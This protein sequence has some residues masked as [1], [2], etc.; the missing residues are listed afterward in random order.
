ME[1]I[2]E[3]LV[4]RGYAVWNMSYRRLGEPFGGWPAGLDDAIAGI[5]ALQK[6]QREGADL[7]LSRVVLVGHS[8][9]GHLA[10]MAAPRLNRAWRLSKVLAVAGLAPVTDLTAADGNHDDAE[11]V[12]GLLGSA[13]TRDEQVEA[14]PID[15]LPLG[16]A[17]LI[18][19]GDRD[20]A[21]PLAMSQS[22]VARASDAGDQITLSVVYGGEHMDFLDPA[23][24]SH[25]LLCRWLREMA[26]P[27]KPGSRPSVT[28]A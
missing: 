7:D 1:R 27:E 19:H 18:L 10:L 17:Q 5:E 16:V 23:S 2:A 3:D 13:A 28:A 22:Y 15:Q 4:T 11:A 24:Q 8:A 20:E 6:V 14:S 25:Q 9:G 26:D 21:V 12:K